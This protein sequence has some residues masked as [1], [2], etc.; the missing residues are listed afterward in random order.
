MSINTLKHKGAGPQVLTGNLLK[1]GTVVYLRAD[2]TWG[3]LF[4]EALQSENLETIKTMQDIAIKSV[5][6]NLL[7]EAYFIDID[8]DTLLPARYREKFR[9]NGPSFD[10]G[11]PRHQDVLNAYANTSSKP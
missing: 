5:H 7:T 6:D 8:S 9:A 2:F 11:T 1:E 3:A 4:C 10:P